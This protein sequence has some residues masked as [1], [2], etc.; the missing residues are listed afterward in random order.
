MIELKTKPG[1]AAFLTWH[2]ATE[3][4]CNMGRARKQ[5]PKIARDKASRDDTY[6][7]KGM[8]RD[9]DRRDKDRSVRQAEPC[10]KALERTGFHWRELLSPEWIGL[11]VVGIGL[12]VVPYFR[13][14]YFDAD[15]MVVEQFLCLLLAGTGIWKFIAHRRSQEEWQAAKGLALKAGYQGRLLQPGAPLYD[16]RHLFIFILLIPYLIGFWTAVAPYDNW[17][18][19][20]RYFA[21]ASAFFIVAEA[22][23]RKRGADAFLQ[24]AIQISI[25]WTAF[26][27]IATALGQAMFKDAVLSG[28]LASVFQ[29]PN[30]FGIVLAVGIVGGLLLS[31]R[32][33]WWLQAAG[34]LFLIPMGYVFLLTLSRG[35]WLVF[36]LIYLLGMLLLPFRGQLAYLL[37]SLPLAAGTAALLLGIGTQLEGA[38]PGKV[39]LW[40]GFLSLLGAAGYPLLCR[41]LTGRLLERTSRMLPL[42]A[43]GTTLA[44]TAD[45]ITADAERTVVS[46]ETAATASDVQK[47]QA[48]AKLSWVYQ[49]IL[50]ASFVAV[51][52]ISAYAVLKS[53]TVQGM[54]PETLSQRIA[55]INFETHSVIERGYFNQD[56]YEIY[57]DHVIF[58]TGGG[59]WR[60]LFQRYQ[61]YP[62]WSTQS[63]NYFS[64]LIVE[65]GTVGLILFAMIMLYYLWRG[66]RQ[67]VK[68]AATEQ[69]VTRA[70]FLAVMLGLLGHS[71]IDFN[72]SFGYV[73]FLIFLALAAWQANTPAVVPAGGAPPVHQKTKA[74]FHLFRFLSRA[75]PIPGR[76][77]QPATFLVLL[78]VTVLMIFP[79]YSY[80]QAQASYAEVGKM[81]EAGQVPD[82]LNE[83]ESIIQ[84]SPYNPSYHLT[85]GSVLVSIGTQQKDEQILQ[86]G[87]EHL[88]RAA[89]LAPTNPQNLAQ[90]AQNYARAGEAEQAF[91]AIRQALLY[92]RW[93]IELYPIFMQ[94]AYETGDARLGNGEREKAS[95]AWKMGLDALQQVGPMKESLNQLPETLNKG[96]AFDVT[97][98]MKLLAGKLYY[99]QGQFQEAVNILS[100]FHESQNDAIRRQAIIWSMAAEVQQRIPVEQTTWF[101]QLEQNPD[102][103]DE[104][105]QILTL[106]TL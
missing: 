95:E 32:Q 59:G 104:L 31:L 75:L 98:E 93:D 26:F 17:L 73:G 7:D 16:S 68:A 88:Q 99:R 103:V 71:Y 3:R 37:H 70:Y 78:A 83:L 34:G 69:R 50:P 102:W 76:I 15:M 21:Y 63:H 61:D 67:H 87:L 35:A 47:K 91:Q 10:G 4:I 66:F 81:L 41:F 9:K 106:Q 86:K 82:A 33:A 79:M 36:P 56:A 8:P 25:G 89:E 80:A 43:E 55:Q 92:G 51:I 101:S 64:Q 45:E 39:W 40:I 2:E 96:R 85:Y 11:I 100:Q 90:V 5:K 42:T 29:Y 84:K 60:A 44:D 65:T 27:A 105:R 62:Y 49:L 13:G 52:G 97:E 23:S 24:I 14:L 94:L 53:P 22:V 19:L 12:I 54:L 20:F 1:S 46:A 74:K 38:S 28:R 58:G 48:E 72:M 30:T 6:R 57:R 18:Q 77:L